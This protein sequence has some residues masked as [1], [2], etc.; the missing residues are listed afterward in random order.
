[1]T[2]PRA[3]LDTSVLYAGLRSRRGASFRLLRLAARGAFQPVLSVPLV[4]EYEHATA[5]LATEGFLTAGDIDK[6]IDFLC[7]VGHLQEIYFGWRP[8]LPDPDDD[9]LLELAV[10]ASCRYIVTFNLKDFRGTE[11]FG[12]EALTPAAY[13]AL[14]GGSR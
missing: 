2:A 14:L 5:R 12:V 8:T 3:V 6:A 4:L 13:L 9:F 10:A 11:T 1:M 7:S